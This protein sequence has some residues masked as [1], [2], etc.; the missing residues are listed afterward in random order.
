MI[1]YNPA[2]VEFEVVREECPFECCVNQSYIDKLCPSGYNCVNNKCQQIVKPKIQV[3]C[4]PENPIVFDEVSCLLLD[5]NNNTLASLVTGKLKYDGKEEDLIFSNGT[6]EFKPNS[7]GK[8]TIS[9]PDVLDYS[10]TTY[11]VNVLTPSV[12]WLWI[13]IVAVSFAVIIIVI[14]IIK[15]RKKVK[16]EAPKEPE[17]KML[18]PLP[19]GE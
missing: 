19:R 1:G 18:L 6:A 3:K 2:N 4:S 9:I 17:V 8:F 11:T 10:G 15:K 13:G 7:P 16:K 5:S 12:P 14:W